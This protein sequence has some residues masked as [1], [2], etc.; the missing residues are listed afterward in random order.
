M[1]SMD[2]AAAVRRQIVVMAL[3]LGMLGP[4]CRSSAPAAP[5]ISALPPIPSLPAQSLG[6]SQPPL[7]WVG[8]TL[9]SVT[10][11]RLEVTEAVGSVVRLKRLGNGATAF[12]EVQAGAWHRLAATTPIGTR[13]E[14][15]AETL[16]DGTNLLALRVFLGADCGPA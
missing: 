15:C 9:T 14:V 10:T 6:P 2:R 13:T 12:F 8:G 4:A 7:I 16:M 5:A 3:T 1:R 11:D